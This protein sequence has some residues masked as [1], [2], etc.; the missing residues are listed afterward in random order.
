MRTP[1]FTII[2]PTLNEEKYLPHLLD[3]LTSQTID[4]FE[5]IVA[6]GS[7]RDKTVERA[8]E[9]SQKLPNLRIVK[10]THASLP[11]QRNLG[12][13]NAL[14]EWYVFIDA[15]TILLPYCLERMRLF[16]HKNRPQVFTTL[17]RP[18][19]EVAGDAMITLFG[20]IML[21]GSIVFKRPLTP[22]PLTVVHR[23]I[24]HEIGG[25]DEHHAYHEDVDFGLRI[26]HHGVKLQI[27]RETL[28]VWSLRRLRSQGT[29]K[30]VQQYFVSYIPVL[31]FK[32][33]MNFMPGYVMGGHMYDN[34]KRIK[35]T[36]LKRYELKLKQLLKEYFE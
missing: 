18:D 33:S 12:A 3:S 13:A 6:D 29:L 25:Y 9:Y 19:S 11:L 1:L 27:L 5:I 26:F 36:T 8:Q 34:K 28:W 21:E 2:I 31:L 15:D 30:V 32:R 20:N 22:G 4:D 24:F 16:I 17:Y 23:K 14:G 7:S 10:S 35:Q